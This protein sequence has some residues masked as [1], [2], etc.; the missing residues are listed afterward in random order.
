MISLQSHG[1]ERHSGTK[2]TQVTGIISSS[3]AP[4]CILK[5]KIEQSEDD[6]GHLY[7]Y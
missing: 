2:P 4:G 6:D 5:G 7:I 1:M 3:F